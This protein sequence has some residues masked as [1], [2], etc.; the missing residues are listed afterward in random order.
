[1]ERTIAIGWFILG[2][3]NKR[4]YDALLARFG[5]LERAFRAIDRAL[6]AEIGCRPETIEQTLQRIRAADA[7][8]YASRMRDAGIGLASLEDDAYPTML[9]DVPDPPVFLSYRGDLSI[10]KRPCIGIVGTRAMS[11]YGKRATEAL[12][13]PLV[14]QGVTTVSGLALGVDSAVARQTLA[15][16]GTT[17]AVLGNGLPRIFPPSNARL[18]EEIVAGG[19]LLLSECPFDAV[20]TQFTFPARNRI[21]AGLSR[22]VLVIEAGEKSGALITADLAIDYG[23]EAFAVPGSIF[24]D[25]SKGCHAILARGEAKLVAT[26]EDV[27]C[28]IGIAA[29]AVSGRPGYTAQNQEEERILKIL[30]GF[31]QSSSDLVEASGLAADHVGATLTALELAGVA[32]NTME[33]W[34]R[35]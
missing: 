31:P 5:D 13:P 35:C 26:P 15:A 19:G 29:R 12:I 16:G 4:R 27:L 1:M 25:G 33:G 14:A 9:R 18:A 21:I 11:S 30:S 24:C 10:L 2:I 22:G 6:L 7:H 20:P 8:S 32:G 34:V 28:E 17:A 3:L 23:R